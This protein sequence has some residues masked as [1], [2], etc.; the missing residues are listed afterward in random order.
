[1]AEDL[2]DAERAQLRRTLEALRA[3]L[4]ATLSLQEG[5]AKPVELDQAA[6]GRLSRMDAMQQQNMVDAG[7]RRTQDRLRLVMGALGNADFGACRRCEEPIGFG[8]LNARPE[9]PYCLDC[10]AEM[11]RR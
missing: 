10:A 1:M 11:E 4:D 6:T 9:T 7:R 3:D 5:N 2:T 8:R